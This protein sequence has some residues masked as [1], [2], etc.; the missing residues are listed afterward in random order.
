MKATIT[1]TIATVP[2]AV[3]SAEEVH[4]VAAERQGP[5]ALTRVVPQEAAAHLAEVHQEATVLQG[6]VVRSAEHQDPAVHLAERQ[7]PVAQSVVYLQDPVALS[8]AAA[9][10]PV[11]HSAAAVHVPA[12]HSAAAAQG[13]AD[14]S[15]EAIVVP[16]EAMGIAVAAAVPSAVKMRTSAFIIRCTSRIV[17]PA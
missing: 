15:A 2:P 16:E 17:Q 13:A 6:P 10:G 14:H 1:T 8:M 12:D 5:A 11:D 9:H 4:Q 3:R 7:D